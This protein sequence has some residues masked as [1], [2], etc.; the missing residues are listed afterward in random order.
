MNSIKFIAV[1]CLLLSATALSAQESSNRSSDGKII[2]GPYETNK[3]F[4]NWFMGVAG[5][6]NVYTGEYDWKG[7]FGPR[8]APAIDASIGKWITPT[9]AARVQYSGI[10]G[11]GW[12]T[13]NNVFAREKDGKYYKQK[14]GYHFLHADALWNLSNSF[15]G[16]KEKR[17][18]DFIPYVGFGIARV[19]KEGYTNDKPAGVVGLLNNIRMSDRI[20]LTLEAKQMIV[21]QSFDGETGGSKLEGMSSITVGLSINVGKSSF[22]RVVHTTPNYTPYLKQINTLKNENNE[23]NAQN[24][25]LKD[26]LTAAQNQIANTPKVSNT[27]MALFFSINK[28][29]L[30]N[31]ELLNLDYY[32]QTQL[33]NLGSKKITIIGSADKETGTT[34]YN[35]KLSEQR[36]EYV[37]QILMK[38]YGIPSSQIVIKAIGDTANQFKEP[39]MN[40]TVIMIE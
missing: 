22:K 12:T 27:P 30:D 14:F 8:I 26:K 31:K 28:A 23:L 11:R 29:E 33:K 6:M 19:H 24:N 32:M 36:A 38:K 4:D 16:Y 2:R 13:A 20:D 39:Q 9:V 37:A 1:A 25:T 17:T 10:Q 34:Q 40:R 15:S 7:S 5:G 18:W 3:F 35:Q 21:G